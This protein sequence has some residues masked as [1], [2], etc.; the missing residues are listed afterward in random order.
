MCSTETG[1]ADCRGN[2]QYISAGNVGTALILIDYPNRRRLKIDAHTE[3]R[4][5][6]YDPDPA[7]RLASP[8]YKAKGR[9]RDLAPA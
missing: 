1:R 7:R 3:L 8:G 9:A 6:K 4:E 5:L 2:K